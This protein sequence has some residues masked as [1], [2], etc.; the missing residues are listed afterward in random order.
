MSEFDVIIKL[1]LAATLG[2]LIGLE[3]ETHGRAA[4][5]RTHILVCLGAGLIMLTATYLFEAYQHSSRVDPFRIAAQVVSGIGFLG[6]GTIIRFRAS[7]RGLTTAA[8]LWASAAI[9]L[10]VGCG[11][12]QAALFTTVL[13]LISLLYLTKLES[14][15]LRKDWYKTLSLVTKT[16]PS[17]LEA[18]REI[19]SDYKVEIRD[20]GVDKIDENK[21]TLELHLK[22]SNIRVS[23][24]IISD[25]LNINGIKE[26]RWLE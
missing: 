6:A 5:L 25:I 7:V 9:G 10:A 1:L 4:G 3:R 15:I 2:G 12:Y 26:A 20:L 22:L 24:E 13:V 14:R 23:D 11:F 21:V 19:L 16:G 18:I 17:Q 8:S